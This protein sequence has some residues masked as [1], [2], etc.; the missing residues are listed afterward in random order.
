MLLSEKDVYAAFRNMLLKHLRIVGKDTVHVGE[1]V[2]CLRKSW[3]NRKYGDPGSLNHLSDSKCVI[4][5]LGLASHF[6]LEEAL[7]QLGYVTEKQII[8]EF[9]NGL[10]LAGTPDA[11]NDKVVLEVKTVNRIPDH[12]YEHHVLQLNAYL[13]MLNMDLGLIIYICKRNGRIKIFEVRRDTRKYLQVL[14]R[15][16]RLYY[17]I[18]KDL[19][20]D[21]EPSYLCNYCEWRLYCMVSPSKSSYM[22]NN[23]KSK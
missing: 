22:E 11:Y 4:L 15:A 2:Q 18:S 3:F 10:K 5:G 14:E 23:I 19:P 13:N 8:L 20:P 12:P 16:K 21:P 6:V 1:V 17:H 9:P 7:K